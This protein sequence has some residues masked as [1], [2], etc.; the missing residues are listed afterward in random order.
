MFM[1]LAHTITQHLSTNSMQGYSC[2]CGV[3]KCWQSFDILTYSNLRHTM[4]EIAS[5]RHIRKPKLHST[6]QL[7]RVAVLVDTST[8]WGRRVVTGI[9]NYAITH[10][11]R[12]QIFLE[13]RGLEEHLRVPA[14]WRGDGIIARI[15]SVAMAEDLRR[16]RVP[17][18]NVSGIQLPGV[19]FTRV[20][21]DAQILAKM[22]A[23]HFLERGYRN[24][25]YFSLLGLSY[26]DLQQK[27]FAVAVG[28]AD[29]DCATY[30]VE[31]HEGAEPDWNLDLNQLAQW[32]KSLPKPVGILTWNADGGRQIIYACQHA[33]LHVPEEVA[34]LAGSDDELLCQISS[35]PISAI[36]VAAE[37]IGY[38]AAEQLDSLLNGWP[39]PAGPTLVPPLHVVSRRSTDT[40]AISDAALIKAITFIREHADQSVQV[41]DVARYAGVSRRVL[42]RRFMQILGRTPALEI[43]RVHF[44]HAKKL[45]AETNLNIPDVAEA[46]GFAA[47]EYMASI[48][49]KEIGITPLKYRHKMRNQ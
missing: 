1:V 11:A 38:A 42:E 20:I 23:R 32:L 46:S 27:G 30:G 7:L 49:R 47:P 22:A 17:I 40:L 41:S 36:L 21:T 15:G 16:L 14:G 31:S 39:V 24:F 19:S 26:V 3:T 43:R 29:F 10:N 34:L 12:W 37:Q 33:G 18:V 35:V 2:I 48:F 4:K 8:S 13:A 44:E 28:E 6:R 9:H 5:R 25:A 45:L